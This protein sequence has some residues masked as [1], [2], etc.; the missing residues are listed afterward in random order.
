MAC[1]DSLHVCGRGVPGEPD[2]RPVLQGTFIPT[3]QFNKQ[4]LSLLVAVIGTSLSA[5]LYT[6]QSNQEV[7]EEIALGRRHLRQGIGATRAELR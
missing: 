4:F 6:W 1:V 5:Y 2:L 3:I 7:E